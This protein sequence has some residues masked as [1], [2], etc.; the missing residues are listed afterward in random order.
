MSVAPMPCPDSMYHIGL[1]SLGVNSV[2][3]QIESS[4]LLV[5]ESS[6]R[7][8][9]GASAVAIALSASTAVANNVPAVRRDVFLD[10]TLTYKAIDAS[11][12]K[13]L[14]LSMERGSAVVIAHPHEASIAYLEGALKALPPG[15]E[16]VSLDYLARSSYRA[17]P[18][19]GQI[20]A[21]AHRSP[22]P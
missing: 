7:E 15:V 17:A 9:N 2:C 16:L 6:P 13:A 1:S 22:G 5:P 14:R 21:S 3:D 19:P 4:F 11:F 10:H 12:R 8:T 18:D 20:A